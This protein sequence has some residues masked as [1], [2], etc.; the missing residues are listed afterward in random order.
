MMKYDYPSS[1]PKTAGGRVPAAPHLSAAP[2]GV[3]PPRDC[4]GAEHDAGAVSQWLKP[5]REGDA[6]AL[7]HRL[8]P[9]PTLKL[10]AEQKA[11]WP[12]LLKQG[13]EMYGFLGDVWTTKRVAALLKDAFRSATT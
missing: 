7:T 6:Q 8:P 1:I 11:Q 12:A 2:G 4:P 13:A 5:A 3:E 9:G 10:T